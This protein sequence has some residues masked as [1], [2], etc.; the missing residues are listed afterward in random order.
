MNGKILYATLVVT[1]IVAGSMITARALDLP[2][3]FDEPCTGGMGI[4]A[5]ICNAI[6][7][8]H[9]EQH[10][11]IT[12]IDG[13]ITT[14]ISEQT[15]QNGMQTDIANLQTDKFDTDRIQFTIRNDTDSTSCE[16]ADPPQ[17][18]WC[19]NGINRN[20]FN[21]TDANVSESSFILLHTNGQVPIARGCDVTDTNASSFIVACGAIPAD[22]TQL[23]YIIIE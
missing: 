1:L 8:L 9:D 11:Q 18:G 3:A 5:D 7:D 15:E 23:Y 12:R 14:Q 17:P 22:A 21:V 20:V 2:D 6:N 19:P 10:T 13:T 16:D 4:L